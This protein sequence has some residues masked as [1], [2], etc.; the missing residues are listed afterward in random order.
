MDLSEKG[1]EPVLR[2]FFEFLSRQFVEY[3]LNACKAVPAKRG[4][5]GPSVMDNLLP[6]KSAET[7]CLIQQHG[8]DVLFL[9]HPRTPSSGLK[10][11]KYSEWK[12]IE[13]LQRDRI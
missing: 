5:K 8:A 7:L 1:K 3:I 12:C 13:I 6:H 2:V 10:I 9:P 4:S 11:V